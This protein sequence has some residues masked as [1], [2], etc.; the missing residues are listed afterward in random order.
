MASDI[1]AVCTQLTEDV[2][3]IAIYYE[4]DYEEVLK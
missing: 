1:K 3:K 4:R 2:P